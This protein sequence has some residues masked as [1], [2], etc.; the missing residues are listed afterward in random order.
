MIVLVSKFKRC[1]LFFRSLSNFVC[2][3]PQ[4]NAFIIL[5]FVLFSN[6]PRYTNTVNKRKIRLK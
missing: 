4:T 3:I 2:N 5:S 1:T 6:L